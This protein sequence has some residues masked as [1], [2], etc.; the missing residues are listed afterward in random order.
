MDAIA[1]IKAFNDLFNTYQGRFIRFA[2]SYVRDKD[3]AEDF[4]NEA[5]SYYWENRKNLKSD[6]NI[7]AYI[8]KVIKNKCLNHLQ[9]QQVHLEVTSILM[10]HQQWELQTRI[11]GLQACD[12]E[13][14]FRQE[15]IEIVDRTLNKLPEQTRRVFRMSR[16][17]NKSHKEIAEYLGIT[18]KGVDFH[19]AKAL[20][21]LRRNLNDYITLMFCLIYLRFF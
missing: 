20:K 5:L 13:N 4:T 18:V 1:E 2:Y 7:P 6:S 12:P 15:I 16:I 11:S 3:L 14:V 17:E 21:V 8:L 10:E 19:I 9:H